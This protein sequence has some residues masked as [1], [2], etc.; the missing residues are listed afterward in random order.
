MS[1]HYFGEFTRGAGMRMFR[2]RRSP[3]TLAGRVFQMAL[4]V[5]IVAFVLPRA[6]K[7]VA[8]L[9]GRAPELPAVPSSNG[10][11]GEGS[12]T[13]ARRYDQATTAFVESGKVRPAA[14]A[15]RRAIE[16]PEAA[17]LRE[18]ERRAK[19]QGT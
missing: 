4:G 12:R 7:A 11:E 18:A 3:R 2:P 1:T 13:A 15:A 10:N 6:R 17:E 8:A 5:G 16:G 19:Q 14:A 9:I